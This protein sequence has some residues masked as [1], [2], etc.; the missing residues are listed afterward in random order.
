MKENLK[1][2]YRFSSLFGKINGIRLFVNLKFGKLTNIQVP[3]IK[4][5]ISLRKGTSDVPTF[6]QVFLN[7]EYDI[8]FIDNPKVIIDGGANIGLFTVFIKNK[9]PDSKVISIEPD[10][11]NFE[12]LKKNVSG[13]ENI[14]CENR[15]LWKTETNLKVY[16]K[17]DRG[18]WG[19]MVEETSEEGDVKA[20]SI[21]SIMDKHSINKIDILKLDIE[22]SEKN[23]FSGD[24]QNWLSKTRMVII[25]LHDFMEEGCA[26]P[27]F[28][29]INS[30]YQ[31]YEYAIKGENT[32]IYNKDID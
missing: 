21:N 16:D 18:K 30:S 13:Y 17:L 2:L 28:V 5:S 12:I 22:T 32:I 1:L 24:Y 29:A 8:N 7:N 25:E 31:K 20:L 3:G 27:F 15:G 11:E 19:M 10:K 23:L 26:K 9:F 6:F 4:S 14:F